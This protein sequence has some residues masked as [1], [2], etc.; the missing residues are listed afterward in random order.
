MAGSPRASTYPHVPSSRTGMRPSERLPTAWYSPGSRPT[1][2]ENSAIRP[3]PI[4][5]PIAIPATPPRNGFP[6][7]SPGRSATKPSGATYTHSCRSQT[8]ASP[9]EKSSAQSKR[10]GIASAPLRSMKPTIGPSRTT[11]RPFE[12]GRCAPR[13][14]ERTRG[15]AR[16]PSG[17]VGVPQGRTEPHRSQPLGEGLGGVEPRGD[18]HPAR[19]SMNPHLPPNRTRNRGPA[20]AGRSGPAA[21]ATETSAS[22]ASALFQ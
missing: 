16:Y 12:N 22:N 13:R 10:A 19:R 18:R 17:R 1:R 21:A 5:M 11:A 15:R 20:A 7:I 3:L 14:R 4:P 9:S 8:A 6:P 2:Q